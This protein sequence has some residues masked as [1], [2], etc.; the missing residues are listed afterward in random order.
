MKVCT[1]AMSVRGRGLS[2]RN[3]TELIGGWFYS[4]SFSIK[5]GEISPLGYVWQV[6]AREKISTL[7]FIVYLCVEGSLA[8]GGGLPYPSHPFSRPPPAPEPCNTIIFLGNYFL[9]ESN[10]SS[11][12]KRRSNLFDAISWI[13]LNSGGKMITTGSPY[14]SVNCFLLNVNCVPPPLLH[15][16]LDVLK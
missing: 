12:R 7:V 2:R 9:R 4:E 8:V 5:R 16:E 13:R 14:M 11:F 3:K 1:S 10:R 15:S 6:G